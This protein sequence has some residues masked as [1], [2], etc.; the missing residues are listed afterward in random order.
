MKMAAIVHLVPIAAETTLFASM[1]HKKQ[2]PFDN[3]FCWGAMMDGLK[4]ILQR[5]GNKRQQD[6]FYNGWTHET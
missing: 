3:F 4:L 6:N 5:P 1:I 2:E